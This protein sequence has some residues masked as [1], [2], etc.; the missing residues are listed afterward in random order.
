[1]KKIF[2]LFYALLFLKGSAVLFAQNNSCTHRYQ[3]RYFDSI[4]VI[5]D[6]VYT[7]EA[8][9]VIAAAL[10]VET[11]SRR[12]LKMDI[13]MPPISDTVVKRPVVILAHGGG[14][15][16]IAFMGGT[17]LVGTMH[18]ED[19]QALADTLA[20]WGFVA[21]SIEY[22]TGFD[23][24]STTSVKRA[25]WRG[26]QDMSAAIRFFRK[27][28][29]VFKIDTEKV[30]IGGSSAGA[31]AAIHATFVDGDE[32]IAESHHQTAIVMT[33][34][35]ELH[36]R[37]IVSI[38]NTNDFSGVS[39][40]GNDVDSIAN[41]VVGYWG[42]IADTAMFRGNNKAPIIMFHGDEDAVVD[43]DCARPFSG[44]LFTAPTTCGSRI[45]NEAL[46][47]LNLPHEYYMA[48]GEGHE[49]WGVTNGMWGS[50]G[51]NAF[52]SDMIA[53]TTSF[54]YDLM[55]PNTPRVNGEM[56]VNLN[57]IYTYTVGNYTADYKYCWEVTNGTII[58]QQNNSITIQ[59]NS[60]NIGYFNIIAVDAAQT[61]SNT[62]YYQVTV[63]QNVSIN[64]FAINTAAFKLFPNPNNGNFYIATNS[65]PQEQVIFQIFDVQGRLVHE[66]NYTFQGEENF[67]IQTQNLAQGLYTIRAIAEDYLSIQKL[68]IQ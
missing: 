7:K 18:N 34:L 23:M 51:P 48:E 35:G 68:I 28:A 58:A 11:I 15:V 57:N 21:A 60:N 19:I 54:I 63:N 3:A 32:R 24:L 33:D 45:M 22:R 27:N 43:I 64:E 8:P 50:N 39:A 26:S 30:F 44:I 36:S 9:K 66:E 65:L 2:F 16:D 4:Q 47:R 62:A 1:M 46:N 55:R 37:P 14:F 25:V 52:W 13:F 29:S 41:G 10:G 31:F 49:Y 61:K 59:W 12:D 67:Q 38:N 42:A 53:K 17:L 20:H 5:R 6:I 40:L 56:I